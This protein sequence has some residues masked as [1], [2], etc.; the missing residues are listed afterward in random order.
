MKGIFKKV[1]CFYASILCAAALVLGTAGAVWADVDDTL[2]QQMITTAEGLTQTIVQLTDDQIE[3]YSKSSDSFTTSAMTAWSGAKDELGTMKEDQSKAGETDFSEANGEYTITVP[4]AFEKSDAKFV[5][6]FNESGAP[7]SVNVDIQYSM[8]DTLKRAAMNTVMGLATVFCVLFFLMFVIWLFRFI[9]NGSKKKTEAP[10]AVP[11]SA[12]VA[13][14]V[15]E[16][17]ADDG[18]LV[19]VIAAAIA[20]AEGTST[21][22]FVVRSIRKVNRKKW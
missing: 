10:A 18:E 20:A 2:K 17:T 8:S 11:A 16:E 12:P 22:S 1:S 13:A 6:V 21:D 15:V 7:T 14:P 4:V 3:A 19:A 5:Y 9:P